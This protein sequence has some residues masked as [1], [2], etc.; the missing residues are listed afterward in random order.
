MSLRSFHVFFMVL[1]ILLAAGFGYWG[2][3]ISRDSLD[4]WLGIGSLISGAF[5]IVYLAWFLRKIKKL[6]SAA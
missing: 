5:L 4:R 6:D 3:M 1:S 2:I